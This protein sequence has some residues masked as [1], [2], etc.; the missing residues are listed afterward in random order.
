MK[1]QLLAGAY[2]GRALPTVRYPNSSKPSHYIFMWSAGLLEVEI[3]Q[4][5]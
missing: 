5:Q 4:L 1:M 3:R 2:P